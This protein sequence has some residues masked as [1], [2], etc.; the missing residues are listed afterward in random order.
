MARAAYYM[1]FRELVLLGVA[2]RGSNLL[3]LSEANACR[4]STDDR[5]LCDLF[6]DA[7]V[8]LRAAVLSR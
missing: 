6:Q 4:C 5:H 3:L 8:V 1:G 7:D 2:F